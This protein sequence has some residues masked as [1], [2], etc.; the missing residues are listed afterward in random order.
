MILDGD[1]D[2]MED[3]NYKA[4]VANDNKSKCILL[5]LMVPGDKEAKNQ[6]LVFVDACNESL[7]VIISKVG[8]VQIIPW[9]C[10]ELLS[11]TKRW[12][13]IPKDLALAETVLHGF[14]RFQNS[15]KGFFRVQ[16]S[17]PATVLHGTLVEA[18]RTVNVPY[19]RFVQPAASPALDPITLGMLS[20]TVPSMEKNSTFNKLLCHI[21]DVSNIGTH[22]ATQNVPGSSKIPDS[23]PW[24]ACRIL[25]IEVD[26]NESDAKALP[27]A[28]ADFFNV[29]VTPGNGPLLGM[30]A[31]F[32]YLP[33]GWQASSKTKSSV[34]RN[35]LV[36]HTSFNLGIQETIL[37]G[38]RLLNKLPSGQTML[39]A[40][41]Q[42][43]SLNPMTNKD[44]KTIS[45]R[46]FVGFIP[47]EDPEIWMAYYPTIFK[48][49]AE[50]VAAALPQFIEQQWN[51]QAKYFCRTAFIVSL[52]A[53]GVYD[54]S[55][56][57]FT[58]KDELEESARLH[59]AGI[60]L[61]LPV[62]FTAAPTEKFISAEHQRAF[63]VNADD[64]DTVDTDL[65]NKTP[66][67]MNKAVTRG[68][69]VSGVPCR[70]G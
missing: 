18:S 47:T 25:L 27:R 50:S 16:I 53:D 57:T 10:T 19:Q 49:E 56:R 35:I 30:S 62:A 68:E 70:R 5:T 41:L 12:N 55:S 69:E 24:K 61:I 58:T 9:K 33:N 37:C 32:T 1:L 29:L 34:K 44:G 23:I 52:L 28:F 8:Q 38:V 26:R 13:A 31:N 66:V 22:W 39:R 7:G 3:D 67:A 6:A 65:R 11:S 42:L 21:F 20:M 4:T 60:E 15:T 63:A 43:P 40:L 46:V 2:D 14:N 64:A 17:Y 51:I 48:S 36:H 45:G 59:S 54:H